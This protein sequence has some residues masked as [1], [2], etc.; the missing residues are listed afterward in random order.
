MGT[1][2]GEVVET[3]P[4]CYSCKVHQSICRELRKVV[5]RIEKLLPNIEAARPRCQSGI[6]V[7]CLLNDA[8]DRAKQVLEHCS[9]SSKLYLVSAFA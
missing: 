2:A 7:L 4:W 5:D 6:Q 3:F 9:E 8:L 1:D